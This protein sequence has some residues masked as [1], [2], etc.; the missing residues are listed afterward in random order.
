[1]PTF[2]EQVTEAVKE[3]RMHGRDW[4]YDAV[5]NPEED[6]EDIDIRPLGEVLAEARSGDVLDVYCYKLVKNGEW[7]ELGGNVEVTLA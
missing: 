2:H 7:D 3:E 5:L 6:A 4:R 1:M